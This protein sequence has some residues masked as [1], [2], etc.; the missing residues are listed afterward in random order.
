MILMII[1]MI[2][3]IVIIIIIILKIVIIIN[4]FALKRVEYE[5]MKSQRAG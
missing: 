1:T 4:S 3:I 5:V 2:M